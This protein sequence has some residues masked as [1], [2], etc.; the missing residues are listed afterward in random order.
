[1]KIV[2]DYVR[3]MLFCA[4]L[5]LGIQIPAL[6]D[7]YTKRVDAKLLESSQLLA[8]FQLTAD[9]YFKGSI[10]QL[11]QHYKQSS[12]PVFNQDSQNIQFIYER[13]QRLKAEFAALQGNSL[14]KAFHVLVRHD[15][16]I[17]Q[18][19]LSSY[20]YVIILDPSAFLWGFACA[21]FLSSFI[22]SLMKLLG[23]CIFKT[24]R[25]R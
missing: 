18:E 20:S 21:L 12:D 17:L 11:I 10:E 19:T 1:M 3:L 15:N 16:A 9:R 13:V 23:L 22:E 6:T 8:G 25:A 14:S 2:N 4:G 7:Q 24:K 5:L